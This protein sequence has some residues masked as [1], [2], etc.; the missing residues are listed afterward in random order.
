M[1][2]GRK[3]KPRTRPT[4][5]IG[6]TGEG[7]PVK[8]NS[9]P[10]KHELGWFIAAPLSNRLYQK[11]A[12]GKPIDGGIILTEE[13]IMFCHWHRHVPLTEGWV[14]DRL[15]EDPNFVYKSVAY[16]VVRSAGEKVVPVDERWLRW[17][18]ESHPFVFRHERPSMILHGR[19][20]PGRVA[21]DPCSPPA[22]CGHR[23]GQWCPSCPT[24]H[25]VV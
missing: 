6:L 23:G 1:A 16:D 12:L 4:R 17:S 5:P 7:S 19:P 22:T 10:D 24:S 9:P 15:S 13:E 11:S 18:R 2:E 14:D 25:K 20:L 8:S 21:A 3:S